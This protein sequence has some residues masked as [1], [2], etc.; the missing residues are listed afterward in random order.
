MY[1][2]IITEKPSAAKKIAYALADKSPDEVKEKGVTYYNLTRDGKRIVVVSAV[3]HLYTVAENEKSFKYPSYDIAWFPSHKI[4]KGASYTKK[5]LDVI[6]K[7][8]KNADS[9]TVACDFDV[10]GE[11]IG[12]NVVRFIC[13]Q[14]DAGRM[15]FSTLVKSD[16]EKSYDSKEKTL[17]WGQA[18]AGE[19][20]HFIDWLYGINISRALMTAV[21]AA[22][23]FKILSSGRVQGPALK[24]LAE[25]EKSI[26]AFE[27]V[28]YWQLKIVTLHNKDTLES[29]HEEDKFWDEKKSDVSLSAAKSV[30]DALVSD[31]NSRSWKQKPPIPFD[32]GGLQAEAYKLFNFSP[33]RT[34]Q[35]AQS[36]YLK[37]IT[38]YPRTSSQ[39]L[40]KE[41]GFKKILGELKKIPE[42]SVLVDKL[43][44]LGSLSPNNGKK[45]DPA[46][47]AIYPT[48]QKGSVAGDDRKLY[49]LI[50]KR[51]FAVFGPNATKETVKISFDA[52]GEIFK[53]KGSTT[54]DPGWHIF[55]MPYAKQKEEELPSLVQG[56]K[57]PIKSVR[58]ESKKT[59]PPKRFTQASLISDLEKR[60]LGTKATRADIVQ[61]LYDRGY[62]VE[63]NLQVTELGMKLIEILD[64]YSPEIV[65]EKLAR[66]VE[67]DTEDVKVQK[68]KPENVLTVVKETLSKELKKFKD[69]EK[70]IGAQFIES[71]R[72]TQ[73]HLNTLGACPV[74][75]EGSIKLRKGKYGG[76]AACD[77]YPE[78]KTTFSIPKGVLVKATEEVSS[79]GYPVVEVVKKGKRP[80]K[81]SINPMDNISEDQKSIVKKLEGAIYKDPGSGIELTLRYG[82]YGPFLA[83]KN[84][85]KEKKIISLD[86]VK[87][88]N[89]VAE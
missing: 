11:V 32:L 54:K 8:T 45:K 4:D 59:E 29:V 13:N 30:S 31:I 5:Y 38:S 68:Q 18:L 47:P 3:G 77:A 72:E 10:E 74:C 12:L 62:V 25:K 76:F 71:H 75:K 43:L 17:A 41:L 20:R 78:C 55:Y 39:Q 70:V 9:F 26:Q 40:P 53:V 23:S 49:D 50:V 61:S 73:D 85:P 52:G 57:V 15:K 6:K 1:E 51:F 27:P 58:K 21:K 56:D 63:K 81:L 46:H 34:L 33:K 60:N 89:I 42:Y 7:V 82:F 24:I 64:K 44:G 35:I 22:G 66:K 80:Q 67:Q 37:G 84:Y 48:G 16:I 65:N 14:K 79:S 69:N 36:L 19:T 88:E 28:P 86:S 83:A 87:E 2:L